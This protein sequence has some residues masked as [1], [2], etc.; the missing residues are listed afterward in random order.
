[1]QLTDLVK[2]RPLDEKPGD[3]ARCPECGSKELYDLG[4]R[5]TLLGWSGPVNPNHRWHKF[6]CRA[7]KLSFT[8]EV[9]GNNV[10]YTKQIGEG[11]HHGIALVIK[12]MPSCFELYIYTCTKCGSRV[13]RTRTKMDGITPTEVLSTRLVDGKTVREYRTFYACG[14]CGARLEVDEF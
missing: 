8:R 1:M 9:K 10:W 2:E 6:D 5:S 11:G 12:G 7:C 4:G 14:G 3:P 13:Q